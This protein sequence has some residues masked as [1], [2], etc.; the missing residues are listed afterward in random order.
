MRR[1]LRQQ[2]DGYGTDWLEAVSR[3]L[4]SAVEAHAAFRRARVAMLFHPL[5]DE[6]DVRPLLYR[7]VQSKTLLLPVVEGGE[8]L[9]RKYGGEESL[10]AGAYGIKEP[11]GEFF[12]DY[13]AIDFILV[14]GQAFTPQGNRLGRGGGF[15]DRFLSRPDLHA[16][17]LGICYPFRILEH[18]PSEAHDV[19]VD[20]VVRICDE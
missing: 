7:Y 8:M 4:V 9:L 13:A 11:A 20:E 17:T 2:Q 15:Y 14:P 16:Y 6:P 18:L 12:A 1:R 5:P 19:S 10:H 3:R